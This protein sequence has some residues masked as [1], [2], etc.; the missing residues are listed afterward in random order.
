MAGNDDLIA[1]LHNAERAQFRARDWTWM[2][3]HNADARKLFME[4]ATTLA[5][6]AATIERLEERCAAY[7]GQVKAG[8]AEIE[9]LKAGKEAAATEIV[10][11]VKERDEAHANHQWAQAR[12]DA[13]EARAET[14]E[15]DLAE[16][17][18]EVGRKDAAL[19]RADQFITNG[20]ELGFIRMPA[21][22]TPDPAHETPGIIRAAL[23]KG[24]ENG[25]A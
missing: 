25:D 5:E 17:R 23:A 11:L 15:R 8:A 2:P 1:R 3:I 14:A 21:A 22:G 10:R 13:A 19:R 6:Q 20:I 7:K 16:A 4:A 24:G 12:L 18:A 9:R